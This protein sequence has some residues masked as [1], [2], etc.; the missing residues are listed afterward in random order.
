MLT[1][2]CK[3]L[4]DDGSVKEFIVT[5]NDQ[6]SAEDIISRMGMRLLSLKKVPAL[7]LDRNELLLFTQTFRML[8]R[9]LIS[10][11]DAVE[12]SKNSFKKDKLKQLADAILR[13]LE[14]GES[15]SSIL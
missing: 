10:L 15:F 5:S 8:L 11:K 9:S 4:S 1:F 3:V 13:G 7:K 12:M 2:K 14:A 6:K